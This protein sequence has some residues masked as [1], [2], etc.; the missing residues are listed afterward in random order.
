MQRTFAAFLLFSA[1]ALVPAASAGE[2]AI[3]GAWEAAHPDNDD[4][5]YIVLEDRGKAQIVAEYEVPMPAK[6]RL[7]SI[8]YGKW[9][10]KGNDVAITYAEVTDRLRYVPREPLSA[11]GLRGTAPALKPIGQPDARS[12]IGSEVLWKAPHAYHVKASETAQ[13]PSA[14]DTRSEPAK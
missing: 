14:P 6:Q 7:R 10:R 13:P 12:K 9:T 1:S 11:V 3:A 2:P 4:R 8:T 5:L